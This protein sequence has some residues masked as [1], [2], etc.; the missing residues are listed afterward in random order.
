M[1][2]AGPANAPRHRLNTLAVLVPTAPNNLTRSMMR[3]R[4][5]VFA[6]LFAVLPAATASAQDVPWMG[7][8]YKCTGRQC[9]VEGG[10]AYIRQQGTRITCISETG[11]TSEG[12]IVGPRLMRCF[13]VE[14]VISGRRDVIRWPGYRWIRLTSR[15]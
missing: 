6:A 7:G 11:A 15:Q 1:R 4:H 9:G 13:G 8:A 12:R 5:A 3:L 10:G 2:T 14:G